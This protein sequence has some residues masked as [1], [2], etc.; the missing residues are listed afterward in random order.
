MKKKPII[1]ISGSIIIESDGVF[2]GYHR[3]YV[4]DDYVDS[5]IQAGG[6]PFIIP[7]NSDED[8]IQEEVNQL[9]GLILSG[10]HDVDPLNYDEEPRQKLTTIFPER[11]TFDSLLIKYAEQKGLPILG[12]CRGIQI[13]NVY[14]GGTLTQDLSYANHELLGHSQ[15]SGPTIHTHSLNVQQNTFF[16]KLFNHEHKIY[17]NSFHHQVINKVAN[18]FEIGLVAPDGVV[19]GIRNTNYD[20]LEFAVQFHPEMLHRID[21]HAKDI[22]KFLINTATERRE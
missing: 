1:G 6:I 12:I 20:G 2:A 8:V 22:F 17:V 3:S 19:E 9:D 15:A 7:F 13:L 16:D 10:G 14:H 21:P 11:D 4:N 5:V 18:D